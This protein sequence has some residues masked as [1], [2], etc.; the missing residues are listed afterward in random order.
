MF[1][2]PFTTQSRLPMFV[3]NG[4]SCIVC[5]SS[6]CCPHQIRYTCKSLFSAAISSSILEK[7]PFWYL[8]SFW[9]SPKGVPDAVNTKRGKCMRDVR[10]LEISPAQCGHSLQIISTSMGSLLPT[11][12]REFHQQKSPNLQCIAP[13]WHGIIVETEHDLCIKFSCRDRSRPSAA[14]T[15]CERSKQ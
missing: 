6:V 12:P 9:S 5:S 3:P 2:F 8:V 15:L 13:L 7:I 14:H 4:Y 10:R 1:P 11:P